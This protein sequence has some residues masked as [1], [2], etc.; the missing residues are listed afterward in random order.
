MFD[1]KQALQSIEK[2]I[3]NIALGTD[4][5]ELYE[6]IR[7]IMD[8]GGKRIRP[9]LV[10]I[11]NYLFADNWQKNIQPALAVEIFHNFTLLHDDIMDNAPIRRGKPT[12]HEKWNSNIALLS[13]DVMLVKAYQ[14]LDFV[15]E[16]YF[17]TILRKFHQCAIEV[18]EGQQLDMNFEKVEKISETQ[19][20]N[21]IRLKTAVLLGFSLEFGA[22]IGGASPQ[23]AQELY[24]FGVNIGIGFQL[25]DDLLDVY[26][27]QNKFGKQVGGDIIANKK[28]FLL[29]KALEKAKGETQAQLQYWLKKEDFDK[30]E[31]VKAVVEIYNSLNIKQ[32]T[33]SKINEYFDKAFQNLD[34]IS[35]KKEKKDA[36]L[37][38]TNDL[39][40]REK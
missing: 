26:S 40:N 14:Q 6:P 22:L 15:E 1:F 24:D 31:K 18:C 9:M 38:F 28:T 11:G 4:P 13:G 10:L 2:E 29:I 37:V 32:E 7:Y 27:D 16:K 12:V 25:K 5:A 21:M 17:H 3:L 33:E 23:N 34:S 35:I 20:I 30:E 8:L 36:L 19:Y 39:L